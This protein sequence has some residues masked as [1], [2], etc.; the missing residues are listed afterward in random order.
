[1]LDLTNLEWE[2][3][4][5][6]VRTVFDI[7]VRVYLS[8]EKVNIHTDLSVCEVCVQDVHH[9]SLYSMAA[10]VFLCQACFAYI[11]LH[12]HSMCRWGSVYNTCLLYTSPSPRDATLSRMPSSA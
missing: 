4:P 8:W 2:A 6:C 12:V 3:L 1:M 9:T 10:S 7:L 11:G 5:V